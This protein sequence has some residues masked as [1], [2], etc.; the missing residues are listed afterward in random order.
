MS[1]GGEI[2][3]SLGMGERDRVLAVA[4]LAGGAPREVATGAIDAAYLPDGKL[5][6]ARASDAGSRVELPGGKVVFQTHAV[7]TNLRASRKGDKLAFLEYAVPNDD[8]GHVVVI[9]LPSGKTRTLGPEFNSVRGVAFS[10][11][12]REVWVTGGDNTNRALHGID[13]AT[14]ADRI[15][16][17][18]P[19]EAVLSDVHPDGRVL[20]AIWNY[21]VRLVGQ[22]PGGERPLDLAWFDRNE[23]AGL[24]PDGKLM[25]FYDGGDAGGANYMTYIRALTGEPAVRI[26]PGR[27]F[28]LSPDGKWALVAPE[29][30]WAKLMMVPTGAGDSKPQPSGPIAGTFD[31]RFTSRGDRWV[32]L[33]RAET[34]PPRLWLQQDGQP[35]VPFGP[36]AVWRMF[37][38]SPDD[39]VVAVR[40]RDDSLLVP[41]D[42]SP[43]RKLEGLSPDDIPISF[44]SNGKAVLVGR[45]NQGVFSYDLATKKQTK[46]FG[47]PAAGA[48]GEL[49]RG[50]IALDGKAYVYS[51]RNASSELFLVEGLK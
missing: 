11:D 27:G 31:G 45:R 10:A 29:A 47:N 51:L 36:D 15:V 37:E 46:L 12:E 41:L 13:L 1:P 28:A 38:I 26:A 49:S 23:L 25:L 6:I 35:P 48:S 7:V 43:A 18:F 14:G 33:A 20:V 42:G 21:Y 22:P 17:T 30:P 9:D 19:G 39:K 3:V 5:V 40:V 44:S 24:T 34:G 2:A 32:L 8:R 16:F 4:D 50:F